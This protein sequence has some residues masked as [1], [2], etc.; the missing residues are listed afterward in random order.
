MKRNKLFWFK[1][2]AV[3]LPIVILCLA[4]ILLRVS[5]YGYNPDLFIKDPDDSSCMV[6]N[7]TASYRFFSDTTNATKG[8]RE[9]FKIVKGAHTFRIFILGEST[10]AGYPYMHNGSFH[11]W[12][13]YR[14]MRTFPDRNFELINVALT[15]VNS[16]TVLDFGKQVV[17]YQPDAVLIYTGHNEYY[18]A[19]GIGST[20]RIAGSRLWILTV[21]KLRQLRFVQLMENGLQGLLHLFNRQ[22]IDTRDNLMKRM[23]AAQEIGYASPAYQQ[24]IDQFDQNINEVCRLFSAAHIPVFL[25]TVVSNEK[26][27]K[28][29]ISA[30]GRYSAAR[31]FARA[32]AAYAAGDFKMA[33]LCYRQAKEYD[34]LRFRAPEG[35]NRSI[36]ACIARHY[37]GVYLADSRRVFEQVSPHGIP[38]KETLLE[39]VHPNLFGYAL[40]SE[41]FYQAMKDSKLIQ[42]SAANEM[43]FPQ[44][45]KSMPVT[46]VDSLYGAY[47][48][49]MLKTGWPFNE[50]IPKGFQRGEGMTEKI[51]GALSVNRISWLNAMDQLFKYSMQS[52][53]KATALKATEAVMLENP[54]NVPYYIYAGR[55]CFEMGDFNSAALYFKKAYLFDPSKANLENIYL[56]CLKADRPE[57]ALRYLIQLREYNDA[58]Q[59]MDK[60]GVLIKEIIALKKS[61]V[62]GVIS[63]SDL[64]EIAVRYRRLNAEEA[65]A[66]YDSKTKFYGVSKSK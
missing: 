41:A 14:L 43:S 53:D 47:Q 7:R 26:D 5:G 32:D 2:S 3:V 20:S 28:P 21:L 63:S 50:P 54:F 58:A 61:A 1:I 11:R 17:A 60:A 31:S 12:L 25:S 29:F 59:A 57:D 40:L 6:M 48:I 15:A 64:Q 16:Y 42:P 8:N 66:K 30:S 38:G 51:A 52:G 23:A 19:L 35:I 24:G 65:A 13:Q 9:R 37:P 27:L 33:Q 4:E 39:H 22:T 36:L 44:L 34:L 46:Q 45:L 62:G 18:G 49:M 56:L 10:T 55:L